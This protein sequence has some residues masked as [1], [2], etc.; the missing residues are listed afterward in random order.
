VLF[1]EDL[2]EHGT[3][4]EKIIAEIPTITLVKQMA[5]ASGLVNIKTHT[6]NEIFEFDNGKAF[7]ESPLVANFLMPAWLETLGEQENER[8]TKKLAELVDNEDGTM[9][10]RFSV[11]ATLITGEK[12]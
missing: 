7:V 2:G 9:S 8:V 12:A 1:N 6:A 4:V 3:A 5:T 10:F 11:K